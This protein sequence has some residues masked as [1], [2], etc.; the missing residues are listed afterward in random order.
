[1][2]NYLFI[3]GNQDGLSIPVAPDLESVQLPA[4]V[5]GQDKYI[6][7]T[8]A[9]GDVVV[10]IYRHESLSPSQ[11]LD[12]LISHYKAWSANRPLRRR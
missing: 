5:T 3:G 8:L 9:V 7:E 10:T 12:L 6:R 2:Q 1:M 4:G 11:I